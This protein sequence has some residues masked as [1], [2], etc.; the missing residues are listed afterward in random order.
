MSAQNDVETDDLHAAMRERSGLPHEG[1]TRELYARVAQAL[2]GPLIRGRHRLSCEGI[3]RLHVD[4]ALHTRV[5]HALM[6]VTWTLS[7]ESPRR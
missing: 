1:I 2:Y 3:H 4:R 5:S 7:S 6:R